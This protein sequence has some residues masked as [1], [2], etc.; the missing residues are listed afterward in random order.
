MTPSGSFQ[1]AFVSM[2]GNAGGN[3]KMGSIRDLIYRSPLLATSPFCWSPGSFIWRVTASG[4]GWSLSPTAVD[5]Y[6]GP[7]PYASLRRDFT[8]RPTL[9]GLQ[10]AQGDWITTVGP[11]ETFGHT[12]DGMLI[13]SITGANDQLV[14]I[15]ATPINP[16]SNMPFWYLNAHPGATAADASWFVVPLSAAAGTPFDLKLAPDI[17]SNDVSAAAAAIGTDDAIVEPLLQVVAQVASLR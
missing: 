9:I 8:A 6:T 16:T 15:D 2:S 1:A 17:T 12:I 14:S 10:D 5:D 3:G 13:A 11:D 4:D 7:L